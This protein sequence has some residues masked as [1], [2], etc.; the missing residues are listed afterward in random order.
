MSCPS[1][2]TDSLNEKQLLFL[3]LERKIKERTR[4]VENDLISGENDNNQTSIDN[5]STVS[6]DNNLSEEEQTEED[7]R[8][9]DEDIGILV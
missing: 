1:V 6:K 9:Y 3:K 5:N 2:Q 8:D 4:D 7:A